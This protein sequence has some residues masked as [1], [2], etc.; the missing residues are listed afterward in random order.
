MF[1][2]RIRE[3]HGRLDVVIANAGTLFSCSLF[4]FS[5]D[6]IV[7]SHIEM[8]RVRGRDAN[9]RAHSSLCGPSY[10]YTSAQILFYASVLFPSGKHRW[11][12]LGIIVLFQAVYS[13]LQASKIPKFILISTHG[14]SMVL[15]LDTPAGYT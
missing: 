3:Q 13:L 15:T 2:E 10:A 1:A 6:D 8:V 9:R 11:Y 4:V 14:A 5:V 12:R 7:C